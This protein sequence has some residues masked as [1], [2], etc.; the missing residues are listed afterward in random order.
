MHHKNSTHFEINVF[1]NIVFSV[2]IRMIKMKTVKL[3]FM[4]RYSVCILRTNTGE[5]L[6]NIFSSYR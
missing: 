4:L 3:S 1:L 5:K 6:Q 2:P